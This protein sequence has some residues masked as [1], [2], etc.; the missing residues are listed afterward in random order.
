MPESANGWKNVGVNLSNPVFQPLILVQCNDI[1]ESEST[2]YSR[3]PSML[4]LTTS[5]S[6]ECQADGVELVVR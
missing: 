6:H 4:H 2:H 1:M 3:I 5:F